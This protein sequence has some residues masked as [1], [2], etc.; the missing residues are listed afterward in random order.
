MKSITIIGKKRDEIKEFDEPNILEINI[1][2]TDPSGPITRWKLSFDELWSLL[3]RGSITPVDAG[4]TIKNKEPSPVLYIK[5]T[6]PEGDDIIHAQ[7][8]MKNWRPNFEIVKVPQPLACKPI[9]PKPCHCQFPG[10]L[11]ESCYRMKT[12]DGCHYRRKS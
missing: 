7:E 5:V 3:E 9:T 2:N 4:A 11:P 1:Q 10:T 6:S 8:V 12:C